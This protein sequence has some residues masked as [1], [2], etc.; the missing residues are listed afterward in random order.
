MSTKKEHAQSPSVT[1]R[2]LDE[3]E[4]DKIRGG[5][6]GQAHVNASQQSFAHNWNNG[7]SAAAYGMSSNAGNKGKKSAS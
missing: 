6:D 1:E 7:G 5:Y 2:E 4:L 3:S